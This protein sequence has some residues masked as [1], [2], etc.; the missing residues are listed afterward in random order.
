MKV[1]IVMSYSGVV[2]VFST[3]EKADEFAAKQPDWYGAVVI[4]RTVDSEEGD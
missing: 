4:P 1:Y 3:R 2:G